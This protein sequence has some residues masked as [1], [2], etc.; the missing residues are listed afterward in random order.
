VQGVVVQAAEAAV[1]EE[2]VKEEEEVT[3]KKKK[4]Q[5]V[6]RRGRQCD[7]VPGHRHRQH[8]NV[9]CLTEAVDPRGNKSGG[10]G[11][12]TGGA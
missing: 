7:N 6:L 10:R 8:N 9:D 1:Q 3:K 5:F 11:M 12:G 2:V 4:S